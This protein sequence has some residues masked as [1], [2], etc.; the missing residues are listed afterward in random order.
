MS[1][2]TAIAV[3]KTAYPTS[4]GAA[5]GPASTVRIGDRQRQDVEEVLG[6]ALAQGYLDVAEFQIRLDQV[7]AA[8]TSVALSRLVAD[9]P[10]EQLR[11]N[12]PARV[13]AR[14]TA[15]RRGVIAHSAAY[16]LGAV[17]M[18]G[19]WLAIAIPTGHWYPWP[20]W[21]I[22]GGAIGVLAHALAVRAVTRHKT[23]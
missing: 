18:A 6:Q 16:L 10:V 22:L 12:D 14:A 5:A 3:R 20:I 11:R 1:C 8:T 17:L 4:T 2:H 21:P 7:A 9:L 19:L 23:R 13:A 15:A